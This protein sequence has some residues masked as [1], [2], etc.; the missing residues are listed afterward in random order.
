[1]CRQAHAG[2]REL[3]ENKRYAKAFRLEQQI[4]FFCLPQ[5]EAAPIPQSLR[6]TDADCLEKAVPGGGGGG[7]NPKAQMKI[8]RGYYAWPL[9][10]PSP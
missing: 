3:E 5:S 1:M 9:P 7:G 6:I 8:F 2:D 10:S 4:D